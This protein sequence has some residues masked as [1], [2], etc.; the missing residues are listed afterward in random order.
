MKTLGILGFG[1][2][3]EAFA[4]GVAASGAKI[5]LLAADP[6]ASRREA[7]E[8]LGIR[9]VADAGALASKSD[10]V[11]F[12]VKP[13]SLPEV[14]EKHRTALAGKPVLSVAA[15]IPIRRYASE[16]HTVDVARFMPNIAA[17]RRQALVGV[18]VHPQAEPEFRER[19]LEIAGSVGICMEVPEP[20]LSAVT[21]LCGSGIA[22]VFAFAHAMA[23]GGVHA[24]LPY[25]TALAMA[26]QTMRGAVALLEEQGASAAHLLTRVTSPAG[27]TIEGI[28]A[29]EQ[30]GLTATVM[31]AVKRAADR[32]MELER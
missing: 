17:T 3:G 2:M 5:G 27:T 28:E 16:L 22:Y 25:D 8:T 10:I 14:L 15:G 4:R 24:G 12:A 29:L 32:A 11:L 30:G 7:A 1:V 26:A 13:Q 23:M 6:L 18:S 9:S 19:A 31:H 21:G 20:Q